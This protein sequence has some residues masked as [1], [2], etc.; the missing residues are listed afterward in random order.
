MNDYAKIVNFDQFDK[1]RDQLGRIVCT[2]GGFDP[3]HPGHASCIIESRH[4]GDT[5]VVVVNGDGFLRRKKGKP[6]MDL[7][8]RC[9]II[10]CLRGVDYVIPFEIEVDQTVNEALRRIRPHVFTKGGALVDRNKIPEWQVCHE[11]GIELVLQVG[12]PKAWN[13]S[14]YLREWGEFWLM[15]HPVI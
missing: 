13:S 3:V 15:T 10:A 4:Y 5:L 2:S 7:K 6:F 14:D 11:L 9:E 8:T 12:K 1:I